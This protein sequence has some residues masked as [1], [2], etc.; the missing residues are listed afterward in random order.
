MLYCAAMERTTLSDPRVV[1]AL[2]PYTVVRLQAEDIRALRAIPGF[3][4]VRGLPAFFV[5][6]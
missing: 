1:E 5:F 2:R 6:E 4:A 3:E